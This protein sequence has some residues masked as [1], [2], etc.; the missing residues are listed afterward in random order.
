MGLWTRQSPTAKHYCY[1]VYRALRPR[2]YNYSYPVDDYFEAVSDLSFRAS[3]VLGT[4]NCQ[5]RE[6]GN[7]KG[8]AEEICVYRYNLSCILPTM[9]VARFG[10]LC[11]S[12]HAVLTDTLACPENVFFFKPNSKCFL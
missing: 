8:I 7:E 11:S 6:E 12:D 3:F 10:M 5:K 2:F 1:L 9:L 4:S